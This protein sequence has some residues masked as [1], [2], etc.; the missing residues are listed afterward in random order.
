MIELPIISAQRLQRA[1]VF[2]NRFFIGDLFLMDIGMGRLGDNEPVVPSTASFG[3]QLHRQLH[4][5]CAP[6]VPVEERHGKG[7][8]V[9][10]AACSNHS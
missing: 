10:G 8:E 2:V 6:I 3:H 4:L 1:D 7:V 9:H 5:G